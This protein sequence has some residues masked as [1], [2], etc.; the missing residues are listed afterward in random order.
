MKP[1]SYEAPCS[2]EEAVRLLA[3][4]G[5][6]ARP[7]AGGTDLLVQIRAGR[8]SP[9]LLVDVKKI[10]ALGELRRLPSGGVEIGAAVPVYRITEDRQLCAD[11][12]CLID[13]AGIIG[14]VAVRGRATVGGNLCNAAPSG[15]SIPALIVLGATCN[16]AGPSGTRTLPVDEFCT[17]PGRNALRPGELLVSI[18]LPPR[19]RGFGAHYLRFI[20]RNEMDIAVVG[21]GAG[22]LLERDLRTI[23][24]ARIALGAVAPTPLLVR[25]A[26]SWLVGKVAGEEAFAEAAAMAQEAASPIDDMRG[27]V[28][29]RRHLVGVLTKR[30]LRGALERAIQYTSEVR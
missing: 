17:G 12:P 2:I 26:G 25:E 7:L 14:G 30:A 22:L 1:Y 20:P 18:Q 8:I 19:R 9:K 23:A 24:S 3:S 28:R 16:I 5:E 4:G 27:N 6:G 13:G 10:P 11:Y 29:Q 21:A 15:D